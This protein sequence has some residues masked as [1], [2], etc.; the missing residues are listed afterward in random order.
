MTRL[1]AIVPVAKQGA[2]DH[3]DHPQSSQTWRPVFLAALAE[4][5]NVSDAALRAGIAPSRAYQ[6][7]RED[8]AFR[9]GWNEALAEGYAHL[10]METLQRLRMGV[11]AGKDDAK[12][13]IAN[14]M[15]LLTLH[16]QGAAQDGTADEGDEEEAIVAILNARIAAARARDAKLATAAENKSGTDD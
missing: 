4:T 15:R 11:S 5:S 13:D 7:R 2:I 8:S 16:R 9:A 12:F 10:E 14:A 1:T 6:A 3:F